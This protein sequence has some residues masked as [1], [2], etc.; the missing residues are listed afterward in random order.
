MMNTDTKPELEQQLLNR[1][2]GLIEAAKKMGLVIT[3]ETKSKEPL[4][5]GNYEMIPSIRNARKMIYI[6]DE[7]LESFVNN[8]NNKDYISVRPFGKDFMVDDSPRENTTFL[9]FIT[10]DQYNR[11]LKGI[12]N[13][14]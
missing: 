13:V 11:Y 9:E 4:A 8:K 5:M 1:L 14:S 6:S 7:F 2:K 3:I 12:V 10:E